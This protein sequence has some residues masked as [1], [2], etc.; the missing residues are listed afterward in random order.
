[1]KE[2]R[3]LFIAAHPRSGTRYTAKLL[4][5]RGVAVEQE[6]LGPEGTVSW[7]HVGR[8]NVRGRLVEEIEFEKIFHQVRH[9]LPT[10]TSTTTISEASY[11]FLRN[12]IEREM[13]CHKEN[14]LLFCMVSWIEWNK[15][16]EQFA[17]WRFQ[18]E[19]LP[20]IWEDFKTNTGLCRDASIPELGAGVRHSRKH[21]Y[22][23][24]KTW[25]ELRATDEAVADEVYEM[26]IRYGYVS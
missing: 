1:M 22:G 17:S 8:G 11:Q 18:I 24:V 20:D 19:M 23:E 2:S 25:D 21:R 14:P 12:N 15:K 16:I 9:P 6:R 3:R 4:K 5:K 10:I 7:V 26:A 13:P